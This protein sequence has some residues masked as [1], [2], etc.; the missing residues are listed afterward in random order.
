MAAKLSRYSLQQ[1]VK[2]FNETESD[3]D[4]DDDA[5]SNSSDSEYIPEKELASE[6]SDHESEE[7][8]DSSSDTSG[9]EA[10]PQPQVCIRLYLPIYLVQLILVQSLTVSVQNLV[11]T[12]DTS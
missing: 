3:N 11:T 9:D 5:D 4:S 12:N 8:N 10:S 6:V 7:F 1:V 2:L